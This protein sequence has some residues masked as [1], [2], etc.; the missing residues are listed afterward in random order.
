L[1][2]YLWSFLNIFIHECGH[3]LTARGFG[4]IADKISVGVG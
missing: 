3:A 4:I 1:F 2:A